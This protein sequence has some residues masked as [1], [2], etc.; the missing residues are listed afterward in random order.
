MIIIINKNKQKVK[1]EQ[2]IYFETYQKL[3][4][5]ASMNPEKLENLMEAELVQWISQN[6]MKDKQSDFENCP[7]TYKGLPSL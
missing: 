2:K 3:K 6:P 4:W 1:E 7:L 5:F